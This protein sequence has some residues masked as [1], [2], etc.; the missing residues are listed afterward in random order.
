LSFRSRLRQKTQEKIEEKQKKRVEKI[1]QKQLEQ[2]NLSINSPIDIA[3]RVSPPPVK[4][5]IF[6]IIKKKNKLVHKQNKFIY[7]FWSFNI[8]I[9]KSA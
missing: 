4:S 6:F 5:K 1:K 7:R 9:S 8:G 3:D 2:L